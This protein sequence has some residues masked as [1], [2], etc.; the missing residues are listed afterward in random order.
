MTFDI[1]TFASVSITP[2]DCVRCTREC[3][4]CDVQPSR[5]ELSSDW[6]APSLWTEPEIVNEAARCLYCKEP[7]CQTGCPAAVNVRDMI[8]AAGA[9]NPFYGGYLAFTANP[10]ALTTAYLCECNEAQCQSSCVLN[11]TNMGPIAVKE[12]QKYVCDQFLN[13][14]IPQQRHP[15][16]PARSEHV[17]VIGSG[18]AGLSA[19]SFLARV[20]VKVTVFEKEATIGGLLTTQI[21]SHRLPADVIERESRLI[22][23]LGV[24]FK[25]GTSVSIEELGDYNAV[26]AGFGAYKD[27]LPSFNLPQNP[28]VHLASAFL[29]NAKKAVEMDLRGKRVTV[30][31]SGNSAI[32]C[33]E[34]AYRLGAS[35]VTLAFRKEFSQ[36]RASKDGLIKSLS[37]GVEFLPCAKPIG[38][39]EK[40]SNINIKFIRMMRSGSDYTETSDVMNV[41]TDVVVLAFGTRQHV[42][43][44]DVDRS[45]GRVADSNVFLGGDAF[46]SKSVIEAVND[47]RTAAAAIYELFAKQKLDK[48]P[49]MHTPV[50][51]VDISTNIDGIHYPNPFAISS[52]PISLTFDHIKKCYDAGFG[53]AVTKTITLN[54]M[55]HVENAVRINKLDHITR[56]NTGWS[57]LCM[58]TDHTIETW[59]EWVEQLKKEYPDRVLI[60]SIMGPDNKEAWENLATTFEKA[61]ADA[62][63]LNLSCPN[64]CS[65]EDSFSDPDAVMAMA[66]GKIPSAV[67]RITNWVSSAVDIPVYTKLTPNV[68]PIADFAKAARAGIV[69]GKRGGVTFS[70][71]FSGLAGIMPNGLPYPQVGKSRTMLES[72]G[73]S[74]TTIRPFVLA[75]LVSIRQALSPSQLSILGVGGVEN[76]KS[77]LELIQ[78][79]ANMVQICSAVQLYDY[80][81]VQ[82]FIA[83]LKF[84]LYAHSTPRLRAWLD[85]CYEQSRLPHC[86]TSWAN[87]S[88][89]ADSKPVS[90]DSQVAKALEFIVGR[91]DLEGPDKWFSKAQINPSLC[92]GCGG[93][94]SSCDSNGGQAIQKKGD[95]Y[96]VDTDACIGCSLCALGVC[97]QNAIDMVEV[98]PLKL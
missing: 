89:I 56:G 47:G 77:A 53:A 40:D 51:E 6:S 33:A 81:I 27:V 74:G 55:I 28:N 2:T 22:K 65:S 92:I 12:I 11:K 59:V 79:G 49:P 20:G 61:G 82:E 31:G 5:A 69:E 98:S 46:G 54:S 66:L 38:V 87:E 80:S 76:A 36:I 15:A 86:N 7:A 35:H 64:Q 25:L 88:P 84:F 67:T 3:S 48:F 18:P 23:D 95:V 29:S 75:G 10:L 26:F 8:K 14:G 13:L 41:T 96:F 97:P 58:I 93:C 78:A 68:E 71:T 21:P 30:L 16:F 83:G 70:N 37:E 17:A 85:S 62:L 50:N 94:A 63:E 24:V 19:A 45:T 60:V 32:D 4:R 42:S 44:T 34:I 57:N 90:L 39:V 52:A 91:D 73:I 9:R 43:F 72:Y 1:E